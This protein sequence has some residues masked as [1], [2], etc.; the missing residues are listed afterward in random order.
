MKFFAH[1][2]RMPADTELRQLIFSTGDLEDSKLLRRFRLARCPGRPR[3]R[4][5][6]LALKEAATMA[7]ALHMSTREFLQGLKR[8]SVQKKAFRHLP[9]PTGLEVVPD[10][11]ALREAQYH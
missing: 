8:P 4:W 2:Y 10:P 6:E 1:A 11:L 7:D 9:P 3:D 5:D